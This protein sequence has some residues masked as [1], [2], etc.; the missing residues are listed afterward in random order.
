MN[1][2]IRVGRIHQYLILFWKYRHLGRHLRRDSEEDQSELRVRTLRTV[3]GITEIYV[4][5]S[6][7]C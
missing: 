1:V 2:L 7:C 6:K 4:T 5:K 3:I